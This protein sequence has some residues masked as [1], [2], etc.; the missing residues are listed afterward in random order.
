M[1]GIAPAYT[2]LNTVSAHHYVSKS[3]WWASVRHDQQRA[4]HSTYGTR[5]FIVSLVQSAG[6]LY[7]IT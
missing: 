6:T 2:W 3:S 7:R 1:H 4:A 5:A